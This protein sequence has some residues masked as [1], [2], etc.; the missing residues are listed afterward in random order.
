MCSG[1]KAWLDPRGY[2]AAENAR[3]PE[4]SL[5]RAI[6][7]TAAIL[8]PVLSLIP[9]LLTVRSN[10]P[11]VS[12]HPFEYHL[13]SHPHS[14]STSSRTSRHIRLSPNRCPSVLQTDEHTTVYSLS[15]ISNSSC[16]IEKDGRTHAARP[17]FLYKPAD[18]AISYSP[19]SFATAL[20]LCCLLSIFPRNTKYR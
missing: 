8:G 10:F 7:E 5:R 16:R 12:G 3:P 2:M 1:S 14:A 9:F 11:R 20:T 17:L 15:Q 4:T 13:K 19:D 18:T 6:K